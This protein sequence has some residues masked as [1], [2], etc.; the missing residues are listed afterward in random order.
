MAARS[1][2]SLLFIPIF[3]ALAIA[4]TWYVRRDPQVER[5]I[6]PPPDQVVALFLRAVNSGETS[7]AAQYLGSDMA[8]LDLQ[9]FHLRL[10]QQFGPAVF[11]TTRVSMLTSNRAI[12]WSDTRTSFA[13]RYAASWVLTRKGDRW[14]IQDVGDFQSLFSDVPGWKL[15]R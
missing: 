10:Q 7:V 12:V 3:T 8:G 15:E 1:I 13:Y 4:G 5:V 14:L 2:I 11:S 9:I 6:E